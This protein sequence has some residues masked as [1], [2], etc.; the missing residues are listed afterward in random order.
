M[1]IVML[2]MRVNSLPIGLM[3]KEQ[4]LFGFGY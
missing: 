3:V 4:V 1:F 2:E